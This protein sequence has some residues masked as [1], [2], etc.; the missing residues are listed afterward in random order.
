MLKKVNLLGTEIDNYT[1]HEALERVESF[2]DERYVE[3]RLREEYREDDGRRLD[4]RRREAQTARRAQKA[5]EAAARR[6]RI[7]FIALPPL[8]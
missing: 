2:L 6:I 1:A 8:C 4:R 7:F 3:E 5:R